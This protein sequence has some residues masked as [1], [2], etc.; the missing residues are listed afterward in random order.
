[1]IQYK[2]DRC[3]KD[4]HGGAFKSFSASPSLLGKA[5]NCVN[6]RAA[7]AGAP[8]ITGELCEACY[9]DFRTFMGWSGKNG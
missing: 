5:S 1:M 6:I 9:S 8:C 2:C 4:G 7:T 3:S